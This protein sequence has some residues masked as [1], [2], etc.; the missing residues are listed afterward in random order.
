MD[1][2]SNVYVA[3]WGSDRVQRWAPGATS[4]V[5][6]AGGNGLGS[7]ANQFNSPIGV[8]VDTAGN[9]YV[10]DWGNY[11]VQRWAP[12]ATSGVT[13]AGGNGDGRPPTNSATLLGVALDRS[14]NVYVVDTLTGGC[15]GWAMVLPTPTVVPGS[16]SVARGQQRHHSPSGAGHPVQRLGPDGDGAVDHR[17]SGG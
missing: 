16:G 12:G 15:S 3:D 2:T 10:A 9:V 17:L 4:G 13:V 8:A 14:D 1:A 6:V 5:T 7:A 11:R